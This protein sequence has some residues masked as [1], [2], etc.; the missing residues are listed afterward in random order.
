MTASGLRALK[1]HIF[2][3]LLNLA[4]RVFILVG[5]A[6]DVIIGNR[7]F[8]P[9]EKE[10]GLVLVF[11]NRMNFEWNDSGISAKLVFGTTPQK[12][13][14]PVDAILSIFS[15]DLNAHFSATPKDAEKAED[16][17]PS[18]RPPRENKKVVKIDFKKRH[19][20]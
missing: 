13:F 15:P 7:G 9:E 5:Y 1:K 17:P 12:C 19:R 14:V 20:G 4:G 10:K 8:L 18:G 3:E 6:E 2:S 11:N 16:A